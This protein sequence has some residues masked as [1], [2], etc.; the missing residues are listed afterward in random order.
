MYVRMYVCRR[1]QGAKCPKI[2]A[3]APGASPTT[4]FRC[5]GPWFL[6]WSG[7]YSEFRGAYIPGPFKPF[8]QPL[9]SSK[10]GMLSV[11]RV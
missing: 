1:S 11:F 2:E 3:E 7:G 8:N 9:W 6:G 5:P 10:L 4:A